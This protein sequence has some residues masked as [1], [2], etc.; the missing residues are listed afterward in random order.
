MSYR[1]TNNF[2]SRKKKTMRDGVEICFA[3]IAPPGQLF[4]RI[5]LAYQKARSRRFDICQQ[6]LVSELVEVINTN[7]K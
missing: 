6:E 1:H 2:E 3:L 5:G 4:S 7:Q